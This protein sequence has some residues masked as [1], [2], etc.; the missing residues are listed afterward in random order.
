MREIH[1]TGTAWICIWLV[2]GL[3]SVASAIR[4]GA[5]AI[6]GAISYQCRIQQERNP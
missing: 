3:G 4:L 1:I 2:F 5:E 6:A